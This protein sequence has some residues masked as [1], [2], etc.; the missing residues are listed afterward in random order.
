M[1]EKKRLGLN[2]RFEGIKSLVDLATLGHLTFGRQSGRRCWKR[3]FLW[4]ESRSRKPSMNKLP[5][6]FAGI[7]LLLLVAP[8]KC[9]PM[10]YGQHDAEVLSEF[11]EKLLEGFT[12]R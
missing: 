1:E 5:S 7:C 9:Q 2:Q 3:A 10:S 11:Q 4:F 6:L 12:V 8:S